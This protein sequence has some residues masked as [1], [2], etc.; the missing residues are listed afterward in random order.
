MC[1][2]ADA[3]PPIYGDPITTATGTPLVLVSSD[4]THIA[5]HAARPHQSRG[6]GVL[7][8]P[9]IRGLSGFYERLTI[10]LAEQGYPAV[11]VDYF[12]RTAG[13]DHRHR[14]GDFPEP[15]H[16]ARL[17]RDGLYA[18]MMAGIEHLRGEGCSDVVSLGFCF[19]GRLAYLSAAPQFALAGAIGL[20]G[21]PDP[22]NG[23]PGPTQQAGDLTAPILAIFGGA[24]PGIPTETVAAFDRALTAAGVP[25]DI[26]TYP[27]APHGFFE[28]EQHDYA[29]SC[30]DAWSRILRFILLVDEARD[31]TTH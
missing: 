6:T 27:G 21:Y 17:T 4:G 13:T 1:Y 23:V 24:D 14:D 22:I 5:A 9:D 30:A 12:G 3:M 25:H 11:A 26:I 19:G 15:Q 2:G 29:E 10:H 20:Y 18:D 28:V 8:L 16:L 31:H 7:V